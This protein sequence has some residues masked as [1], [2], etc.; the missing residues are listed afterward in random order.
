M[1]C[2]LSYSYGSSV[3]LLQHWTPPFVYLIPIFSYLLEDITWAVLSSLSWINFPSLLD[4]SPPTLYLRCYFFQPN[5]IYAHSLQL[6]RPFLSFL[7]Q[8]NCWECF[9]FALTPISL[10]PCLLNVLYFRLL[11]ST[12]Y[13][14]CSSSSI[15]LPHC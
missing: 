9:L 6:P 11:P 14:N 8:L 1:S 3:S 7:L 12:L 15:M 4:L 2:F 10:F 13:E 5:H